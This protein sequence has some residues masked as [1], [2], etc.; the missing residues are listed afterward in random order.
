MQVPRQGKVGSLEPGPGRSYSLKALVE[1]LDALPRSTT[2]AMFMPKDPSNPCADV[3]GLFRTFRTDDKGRAQFVLMVMQ[4]KDWL[5]AP[6]DKSTRKPVNVVQEWREKQTG[7][8]QA[9]SSSESVLCVHAEPRAGQSKGAPVG[10]ELP[11]AVVDVHYV[12]FSS[13]PVASLVA[14]SDVVKAGTDCQ[15]AEAAGAAQNGELVLGS[16][17]SVL[18]L[19][20]LSRWLPTA[21]LNA[22]AAHRLRQMFY[23]E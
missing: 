13:N 12:L 21:G 5:L 8:S 15:A 22:Q 18:D 20:D 23:F 6:T 7:L 4:C 1:R 2:G 3:F 10:F 17:E 14:D 11:G 9:E 16:N 19:S